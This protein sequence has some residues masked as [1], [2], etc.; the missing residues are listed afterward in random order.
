[1]LLFLRQFL[2]DSHHTGA[3]FA[4]SRGL[5]KV[6]TRSLRSARGPL[7][8]LE[9][10]P[11][12]GSFTRWMLRAMDEDDELR[13]V[14]HSPV[15]CRCLEE[16]LLAP[17]RRAHPGTNVCLHCG[18]IETV[19]LAGRFDF[20]VC[21]LPFNNFPPATVRAIFKRML[22]LLA[23]DGELSFMEYALIP[24]LVAA[25][26]RGERRRDLKG[27]RC[28]RAVLRRHHAV[29]RGLVL[30]NL[31]PAYAVRLKK[32]SGADGV[33]FRSRRPK[34]GGAR[35]TTARRSGSSPGS[36]VSRR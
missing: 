11:G 32:L 23:E 13:I 34:R 31:P 14:E 27:L 6:M 9:V 17:F 26:G 29:T 24:S 8:L 33:G 20:V 21:G 1:M 10:G 35:A 16:R 4:S 3:I 12:T 28:V 18:P 25:L 5:A 7:R 19:E 22:G 15:F 30:R 2:R 36:G